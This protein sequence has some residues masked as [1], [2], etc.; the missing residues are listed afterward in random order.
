MADEENKHGLKRYIPADIRRKVRQQSK[1]GCVNC[2]AAI[3][4]YEHID[5]VFED[6]TTHDP[7]GICLLCGG[8]HDRVT[9]GRLSKQTIKA[10]YDRIRTSTD[11]KPPFEELDLQATRPD[12]VLGDIS[13]RYARSIIVVDDAEVLGFR[14]PENGMTFPLLN[15]VICDRNGGVLVRVED[16]TWQGSLDY[17]DIETVGQQI[18]I[19]HGER[20]IALDFE[21]SPPN[22]IVIHRLDMNYGPLRLYRHGDETIVARVDTAPVYAVGFSN[23]Q[24]NAPETAIQIDTKRHPRPACSRVSME[25]GKIV[26]E[27]TGISLGIGGAGALIG[28]IK[29]WSRIFP[30][31]V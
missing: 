30:N 27:G 20:D 6:A 10:Q 17:W 13:V 19:R 1:F 31:S 22:S 12:V 28:G 3:A 9:R 25:G 21:I 16:N 14:A 18:V 4:Q 5:P 24:L 8:C 2:R 11:A 26:L 23:L 29:V 7:D 15:G